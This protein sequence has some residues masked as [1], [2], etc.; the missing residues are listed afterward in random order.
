MGIFDRFM[1]R[2]GHR[3]FDSAINAISDIPVKAEIDD[4]SEKG[5]IQQKCLVCWRKTGSTA[6]ETAP[7]V[8]IAGLDSMAA[9][10]PGQQSGSVIEYYLQAADSSGRTVTLPRS[11]P[12]WFFSFEILQGTPVSVQQY[13]GQGD[14]RVE[15]ELSSVSC[16]PAV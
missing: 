9:A 6:R 5:L 10:L 12:G 14:T 16:A 7:F 13:G 4:R 8:K 2:I 15:L 11:A 3:P 1:L